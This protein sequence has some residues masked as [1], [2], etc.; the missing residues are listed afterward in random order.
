[1][2]NELNPSQSWVSADQPIS[3]QAEDRLG[4]AGYAKELS[5][6]LAGWVGNYSLTVALYGAWGSGKSSIKNMA[7]ESLRAL[8][9]P[10]IIVEFNP[11]R[12]SG[13]DHLATMFF[14][15]IGASIGRDPDRETAEKFSRLWKMYSALLGAG[16][17]VALGTTKLMGLLVGLLALS[18]L[19]ALL[20]PGT[21]LR[22]GIDIGLA[23]L[24]IVV[25]VLLSI[26]KTAAQVA[27]YFDAKATAASQTLEEVK[28]ELVDLLLQRKTPIVVVI[29]D[30]D[31]LTSSQVALM[32]QLIKA[33]ADLPHF[34]YLMLFQRDAVERSLDIISHGRGG[35]FLEKLTQIGLDVPRIEQDQL[36]T[37]LREGLTSLLKNVPDQDFDGLRWNNLYATGLRGYFETLRDVNRYLSSVSF[38]LSIFQSS[39]G[40]EVDVVDLLTIEALRVFEP[41]LYLAIGYSKSSLT[42]SH[43][44]ERSGDD[45]RRDA[46]RRVLEVVPEDRRSDAQALL[47]RL[48]PQ[49]ELV[50]GGTEYDTGFRTE[51]LRARRICSAETFDRFFHFAVVGGDVSNAELDQLV[52]VS[53]RRREALSLLRTFNAR[54]VLGIALQRM[55][56]VGK[57]I[58]GNHAV[59]FLTALFDIGDELSGDASDSL[60]VPK[61][62]AS[63][64]RSISDTSRRAA[65][66]SQA[67]K[68]SKGLV[69]PLLLLELDRRLL[70]EDPPRAL[71]TESDNSTLRQLCVQQ[72][73]AAKL[74]GL[75]HDHPKLWAILIRWLQWGSAEEV[76]QWVADVASVPAG[77]LTIVTAFLKRTILQELHDSASTEKYGIDL[78]DLEPYA[79]IDR[80]R[81]QL[82]GVLQA[83]LPDRRR[84]AL[85]AF[86][87]AV[88]RRATDP[89]LT[90]WW[91]GDE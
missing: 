84:R 31:R 73:R 2:S 81:Q 42:D 87:E 61:C 66:I 79:D 67:I 7:L 21:A 32:F 18:P 29:D 64:V 76:R 56:I 24:F 35:E 16:S 34:V 68:E 46:I 62:V 22:T 69:Q 78:K 58:P 82:E 1:M 53:G 27:T 91:E 19:A 9:A 23:T 77:A 41:A 80:V 70:S 75:L 20:A 11:W 38:Y 25:A 71:L 39:S 36:E 89:H 44:V 52:S 6:A 48:F 28:K 37:L 12:L 49:I 4:R 14:R 45:P 60:V 63:F 40:L 57:S 74:D 10:P 88:R 59:S 50:F 13:E 65:E 33:N 83:D 51:W 3:T 54:G 15:E 8:K 26:S 43:R 72:I 85:R 86:Q 30:I 90:A 17:S 47:Q 55:E 5:R